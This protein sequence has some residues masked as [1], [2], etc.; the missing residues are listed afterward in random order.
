MEMLGVPV[1]MQTPGLWSDNWQQTAKVVG[2]AA[3][4]TQGM[5]QLRGALLT[6][7]ITVISILIWFLHAAKPCVLNHCEAKTIKCSGI[8]IESS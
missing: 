4:R 3:V 6:D 7:V 2:P 1:I 5:A 8:H